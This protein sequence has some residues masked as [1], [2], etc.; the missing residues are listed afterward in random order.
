MIAAFLLKINRFASNTYLYL[1]VGE[2]CECPISGMCGVFHHHGHDVTGKPRNQV[3]TFG[4]LRPVRAL[5]PAMVSAAAASGASA[6]S[7]SR[8][9]RDSSA[10]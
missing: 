4:C 1:H 10:S 8:S 7:Q 2:P 6:S 5:M 3:R 9:R